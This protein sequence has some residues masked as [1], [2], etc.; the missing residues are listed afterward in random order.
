MIFFKCNFLF[1]CGSF[2]QGLFTK[3]VVFFIRK[4][5]NIQQFFFKAPENQISNVVFF[6]IFTE[7]ASSVLNKHVFGSRLL[8]FY[9]DIQSTLFTNA[10]SLLNL[11]FTINIYRYLLPF[12]LVI[13]EGKYLYKRNNLGLIP[14]YKRVE[15]NTNQPLLKSMIRNYE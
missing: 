2:S 11:N 12:F 1:L 4:I 13:Q 7:K 5:L 8:V 10:G 15:L 3:F 6:L 14:K 9:T